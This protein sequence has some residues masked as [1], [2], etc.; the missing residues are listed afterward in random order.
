MGWGIY[1]CKEFEVEKPARIIR[2]GKKK[3]CSH[4]GINIPL[5]AVSVSIDLTV[6][7]LRETG[8]EVNPF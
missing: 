6:F 4:Q 7:I 8:N 2:Q 1:A 3:N 5:V